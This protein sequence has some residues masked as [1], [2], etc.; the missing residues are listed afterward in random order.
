MSH[1]VSCFYFDLACATSSFGTRSS[2]VGT[3][4]PGPFTG[5]LDYL[6]WLGEA[7]EPR[8]VGRAEDVIDLIVRSFAA[9]PVPEPPERTEP[10]VVVAALDHVQ[11]EWRDHMRPMS[12]TELA[13]AAGASKAH[14]ARAFK[15]HFGVG[16]VTLLELVR[17]AR[18]ESLLTRSNLA[19]S[20]IAHACGFTP[21]VGGG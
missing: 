12:L 16:A 2:Q 4:A 20:Q 18:A 14:L 8:W 6:M 9:G 21:R 3:A 15:Q 17:L 1:Q 5:L 7:R 10:P 13:T 19:V 11:R